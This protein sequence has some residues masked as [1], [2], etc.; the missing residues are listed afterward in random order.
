MHACTKGRV[1][2]G[3]L[4]YEATAADRDGRF[5]VAAGYGGMVLNWPLVRRYAVAVLVVALVTLFIELVGPAIEIVNIALLYLLGVLVMATTTGT[6]PGI[7]TSLLSFLAFNFFFVT[8]RY[9]FHVDSAQDGVRLASFLAVATIVS[10]LA[11]RARGAADR[12]RRRAAEIAALYDLSQTISAQVDLERILPAIAETTCRLLRVDA[13]TVLL[14]DGAGRLVIHTSIGQPDPRL[15]AINVPVRNGSIVL[16]ILRVVERTPGGGLG[17]DDRRLHDVL[18]A[19]ARLAVE[20]ARMVEQVAHAQALAESDRLKS[21]LLAAV[22]HDLR[23]PLTIMK[24]ATSTLLLDEVPWDLATQRTLTRAIDAEID[25][26]DRIVGNLLS[27]SRVE[28]GALPAERDWQDL[29]ELLGAVL[30][31]MASQLDDRPLEVDLAPDVPLVAINATLI[32]QVLT[33]LLENALKHTPLGTPIAI[34]ARQG[35]SAAETDDVVVAVR[36]Y[37]PGVP[38]ADLDR[39]FD[40]FYR[41]GEAAVE[42][43]G[44]GLGLAICKGIVEA[45]GGRIWATN[46]SDG[47]M[48]FTFTLPVSISTVGGGLEGAAGPHPTT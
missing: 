48:A 32:D 28:S 40:K 36:D 2:R 15:Q 33:N 19:Q 43:S 34:S 44:A 3:V 26:L 27:M 18:A 5:I 24:G 4:Y 7:L 25:H 10:S 8:P 17:Q 20:R 13:C 47:G 29:A 14:Y 11:A 12:E 9:T 22:S 42:T 31:R 30:R 45:H 16:G 46:C 39:I 6:G 23:T 1:Q 35:M 38:P 37:G 21:A 41:G